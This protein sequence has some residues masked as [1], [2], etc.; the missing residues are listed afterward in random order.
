MVMVEVKS[1]NNAN[2]RYFVTCNSLNLRGQHYIIKNHQ[3]VSLFRNYS[4][5]FRPF[6]SLS[7]LDMS[8][9]NY[10]LC[11]LKLR[12]SFHFEDKCNINNQM[13]CAIYVIVIFAI[14]LA[15]YGILIFR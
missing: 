3:L 6:S 5:N 8:S 1:R 10:L 4:N 14:I 12:D 9:P 2:D 11:F 7:P 13:E 15:I